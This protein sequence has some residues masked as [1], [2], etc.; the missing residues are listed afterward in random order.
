MAETRGGR[1]SRPDGCA[2]ARRGRDVGAGQGAQAENS[3]SRLVTGQGASV[4]ALSLRPTGGIPAA[5]TPS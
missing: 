4:S 1:G 2:E 5:S 3:H